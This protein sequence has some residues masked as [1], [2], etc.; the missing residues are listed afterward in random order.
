MKE[1]LN[2]SITVRMTTDEKKKLTKAA[3]TLGVKPSAVVRLAV[4][5]TLSSRKYD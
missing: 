1:I 3:A 5:K 4:N 2:S